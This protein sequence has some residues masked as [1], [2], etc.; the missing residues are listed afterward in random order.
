MGG[1]Q[2]ADRRVGRGWTS[3]DVG[4]WLVLQVSAA[5]AGIFLHRYCNCFPPGKD[6]ERHLGA[7]SQ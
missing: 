5:R 4:R 6:P 2:E 3:K 7:R 1:R